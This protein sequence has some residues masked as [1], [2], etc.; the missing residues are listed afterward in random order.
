M[1][2]LIKKILKETQKI[3]LGL[4]VLLLV[5]FFLI[6]FVSDFNLLK[7]LIFIGF[8]LIGVNFG[9][10][11]YFSRIPK[12]EKISF[13]S[14][15]Q[16]LLDYLNEGIVIYDKNFKIAF[17]NQAFTK[18]VNLKKEDL[19]GLTISQAMI[20]SEKYEMLANLFFPFIQGEDLKIV[21]Q[22]PEVIEVN[23]SKPREKYFLISYLDI[24]LEKPYKLRVILDRTKDV[25]E[26]KQKLEFVHLVSHNLLTPLTEIRWALEAIDP[27][28]LDENNKEFLN[29]ALR[30]IKN[31]L[32]FVESILAFL[33]LEGKIELKIEEINLEE[34][35]LRILDILKEKIEGKKLKVNLEIIRGEEKALGDPALL[36]ATFFALVE[37]S[38]LYNKMGGSIKILIR[39]QAQ[40]PY[41]EIII[42]DTGIGMSRED[43]ENLF[44]KYYRGKKAKELD[45]RGFGIGLYNAK[46]ITE[47]HGGEIKVESKENI[48]TKVTI[49]LPLDINLIPK[50]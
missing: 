21:S 46:K 11:I 42:E 22:N 27:S 31:T 8:L 13:F 17:V 48:G 49:I 40:R 9:F 20:K 16:N 35:F 7:I 32:A 6:L 12:E 24:F 30:T 47:L 28:S 25:L 5:Y 15:F 1:K 18:I 26:S 4:F 50:S 37:N 2:D 43:L 39:K 41:R 38:I 44:K 34:I 19:I 45:V 36:F 14:L 3:I 23:F 33:R 10:F 29:S